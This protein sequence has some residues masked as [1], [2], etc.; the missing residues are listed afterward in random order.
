M[1]LTLDTIQQVG[2]FTGGPV[3]REVTWTAQ[4]EEVSADVWIRPMS[5]HTAV[6]DAQAMQNGEDML[7]HRLV[8]CVCN[9]DGSPLFRLEDVTGTYDRR[10][11]SGGTP[12]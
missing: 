7:A 6:K 10:L 2:G 8:Q 3:K 5:Y 4:G 9:E 11:H 12:A 1:K